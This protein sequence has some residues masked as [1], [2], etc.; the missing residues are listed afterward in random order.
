VYFENVFICNKGGSKNVFYYWHPVNE[1]EDEIGLCPLLYQCSKM[2][3]D[4]VYVSN[5]NDMDWRL[6][7]AKETLIYLY[8]ECNNSN[9]K[10]VRVAC[11]TIFLCD[12]D[13]K[14][15]FWSLNI[16][17]LSV[18]RETFREYL[19]LKKYGE[20]SKTN[21]LVK[22]IVDSTYFVQC[23]DEKWIEISEGV[24]FGDSC[25]EARTG[26]RLRTPRA[27]YYRCVARGD[28][29]AWIGIL[30]PEYFGDVCDDARNKRIVEHDSVYFK[31]NSGLSWGTPSWGV[32]K[33]ED[34]LPPVFHKD[35]CRENRVVKY[36][37]VYYICRDKEWKALSK[38]EIIPPVL[39]EL[40]CGKSEK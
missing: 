12:R 3:N 25:T 22:G 15:F 32:L 36:G 29:Y 27:K 1:M 23:V 13:Y 37:D 11:D 33:T 16:D 10:K 8:G 38:E 30:A 28:K 18:S 31:C 26:E 14:G 17:S 7:N 35:T 2:Y 5:R 20:C 4:S 39:D 9:Y 19:V 34:I 24:Y 21:N 40:P 6:G